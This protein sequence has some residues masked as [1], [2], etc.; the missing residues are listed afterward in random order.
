MYFTGG[1]WTNLL[2]GELDLN[3]TNIYELWLQAGHVGSKE[4]F[5]LWFFGRAEVAR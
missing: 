4:D 3:N 1:K 2:I 5:L